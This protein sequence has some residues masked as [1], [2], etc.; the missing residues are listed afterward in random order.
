MIRRHY[1][2]VVILTDFNCGIANA[3][4]EMRMQNVFR[5]TATSLEK[6]DGIA[7]HTSFCDWVKDTPPTRPPKVQ[8]I[9]SIPFGHVDYAAHALHTTY[10]ALGSHTR[11]NI[12]VHVTDPGIAHTSHDR[13]MLVTDEGN[14]LIGPN[15]GSLAMMATYFKSRGV[16]FTLYTIDTDKVEMLERIRMARPAYKTPHTFHGRDLF[17][18]VAG[19]VAA[20]VQPHMLAMETQLAKVK[21]SD[22]AS[23]ICMLPEKIGDH[24]TAYAFR[25]N[26]FG[27]LKTNLY[28]SAENVKDLVAQNAVYRIQTTPQKG[29]LNRV[30][31]PKVD[32]PLTEHFHHLKKGSPLMYLGSSFS[33]AWDGR[34]IELAINMRNAGDALDIPA[35]EATALDV[36]RIK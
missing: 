4:I 32:F 31:A 35:Q 22:F 26:T 1:K 25:D 10:R 17:A 6:N 7:P 33:V 9:H 12:F 11:P 15:N 13:T 36:T 5:Y 24:S 2:N 19:L 28:S 14:I 8:N 27:N 23:R 30:F 29:I 16:D 20:G 3:Q 18:V 34:F 21:Q